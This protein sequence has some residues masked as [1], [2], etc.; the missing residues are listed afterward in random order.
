VIWNLDPT[1]W[2]E[3]ACDLAGRNLT[4]DEWQ[5]YIG[6]LAEYNNTCPDAS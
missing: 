1:R 2:A 4:V 3:A 6:D 5:T